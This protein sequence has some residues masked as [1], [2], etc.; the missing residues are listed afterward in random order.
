MGWAEKILT[1]CAVVCLGM[2]SAASLS[3]LKVP[4]GFLPEQTH[5]ICED[6]ARETRPGQNSWIGGRWALVGG[7]RDDES[8]CCT[9]VACYRLFGRG[10][11][12][13]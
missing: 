1:A 12:G 4:G 11:G 3:I 7:A 5:T 6:L 8:A 9:R 10:R 13:G 2:R